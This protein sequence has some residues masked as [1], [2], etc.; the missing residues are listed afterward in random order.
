[1]PIAHEFEYA[2]P[3]TIQEAI[4]I[5]NASPYGLAQSVF[6]QDRDV[7]A[8][9]EAELSTG[10]LNRNRSTNQASPRL[11]F[12]GVKQ[13][14]NFRPAGAWTGR[15]MVYALAEIHEHF[16]ISIGRTAAIVTGIVGPCL[17]IPSFHHYIEVLVATVFVRCHLVVHRVARRIAILHDNG[18]KRS[19][20][21]RTGWPPGCG[22]R[23]D[24]ASGAPCPLA[25]SPHQ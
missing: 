8:R 14:G 20:W 24:V 25:H 22:D 10:I 12:G 19:R 7:F 15:N 21:I 4:A 2:R 17:P 23:S 16:D 18:F 13:S 11:P 5:L 9:Y 3:E 6:T 1:M